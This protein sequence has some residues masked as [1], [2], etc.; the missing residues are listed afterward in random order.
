MQMHVL[1]STF[2]IIA[3]DH[4]VRI[5][6]VKLILLPNFAPNLRLRKF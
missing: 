5:G 2:A 4:G 6:G 1:F 3:R